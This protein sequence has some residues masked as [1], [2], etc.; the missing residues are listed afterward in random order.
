MECIILMKVRIKIW[1]IANKVYKWYD[2][3][4]IGYT[5]IINIKYYRGD[6]MKKLITNLMYISLIGYSI[7]FIGS[8]MGVYP[9]QTKASIVLDNF[10]KVCLAT[11]IM[12]LAKCKKHSKC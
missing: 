9:T 12:L 6:T 11:N 8:L 4:L 3:F 1:F 7:V 10:A 2:I 5:F